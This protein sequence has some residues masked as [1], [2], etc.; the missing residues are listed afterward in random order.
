MPLST[1]RKICQLC[2]IYLDKVKDKM[3]DNFFLGYHKILENMFVSLCILLSLSFHP[4]AICLLTN[5]SV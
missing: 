3:D 1:K 2:E 5:G 4:K